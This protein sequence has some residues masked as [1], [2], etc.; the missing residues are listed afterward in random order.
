MIDREVIV[1]VEVK[2]HGQPAVIRKS[3][4]TW[5]QHL[6]ADMINEIGVGKK[7]LYLAYRM[8]E[9][10]MFGKRADITT[11]GGIRA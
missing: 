11:G 6:S 9:H 5:E 4:R 10:W 7:A 8:N 3:S 2:S 1:L